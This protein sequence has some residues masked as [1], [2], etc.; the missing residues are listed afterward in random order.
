MVVMRG[1][2]VAAGARGAS[3]GA[4]PRRL[5]AMVCIHEIRKSGFVP[6]RMRPATN[7]R[8]I[9]R[10][11]LADARDRDCGKQRSV[12]RG[13]RWLAGARVKGRGLFARARQ[14]LTTEPGQDPDAGVMAEARATAEEAGRLRA[15]MVKLAQ[16]TGY[17]DAG[18][19]D[20]ESMAAFGA[21]W[22]AA[23]PAPAEAIREVVREELGAE[24][25]ALFEHWD[26]RPLAAASLG[27]VHAAG[28]GDRDYAVKVQYPG[29]AEALRGDLS[30]ARVARKLAG[31][32]L[33]RH[34]DDGALA[35]LREAVEREL[36]YRA[37]ATAMAEFA[38][39]FAD[40][41]GVIV[42]AVVPARSAARVLTM[43]RIEGVS[44]SDAAALSQRAR[45]AAGEIIWRF[46][47]TAPL[48]F[49]LLHGDP[50]PGNY[51][52]VDGD[53]VRVAFL[54]YGCTARL[55][56]DA[57]RAE[58]SLWRALIHHD[59]FE[60]AE[61]FR[62]ALHSQGLVP[63]P[64]TFYGESYREWE[65]LASAPVTSS[66]PFR[67]TAA[68]AAALTEATA[69]LA[70]AG[71]LR[72]PAPLPLLWR[73]RLGVVAVLGMLESTVATRARLADRLLGDLG[74]SRS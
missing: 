12:R 30:S 31:A 38:R 2:G 54:D 14:V 67:F 48:R 25:E 39:A 71:S 43:S 15:G 47:W 5:L 65:Q 68:Y 69:R 1:R 45:D 32:E 55:D 19:L 61:R 17:L 13:Q 46:A 29:V 20:A 41:D 8:G 6:G 72:L 62:H 26:E 66:E 33:G 49:G 18:S 56:D 64:R 50:N 36:D 22:D 4:N 11:T 70:R 27:Q 52:I 59:P 74:D 16:L 63:S 37:E 9:A 57:R 10:T 23:P 51:L 44:V 73:H 42:P 24:P 3:G 34:L 21:L 7:V 28:D 60:A 40:D 58:L 35:H 53:P